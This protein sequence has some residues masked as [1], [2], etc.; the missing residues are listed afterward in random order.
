MSEAGAQATLVRQRA[1]VMVQ[2][3]SPATHSMSIRFENESKAN[4]NERRRMHEMPHYMN[5]LS[6][7]TE[8][9]KELVGRPASTQRR[10]PHSKSGHLP[11]NL[12]GSHNVTALILSYKRSHGDR[13]RRL[14]IMKTG[15]KNWFET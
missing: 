12:L 15:L 2:A 3:A 1:G 14:V 13:H 8:Q 9:T 6:C 4:E 5:R 7:E 10:A 11:L